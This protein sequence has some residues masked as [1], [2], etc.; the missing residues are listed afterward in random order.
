MTA[1]SAFKKY[2]P[3]NYIINSHI[4]QHLH[5]W[6]KSMLWASLINI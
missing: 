3:L 2:I 4:L 1:A 5:I 6:C